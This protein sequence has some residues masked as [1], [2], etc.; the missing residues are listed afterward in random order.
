MYDLKTY[1][2]VF[3]LKDLHFLPWEWSLPFFSCADT[4]AKL[5][6]RQKSRGCHRNWLEFICTGN[7]LKHLEL[8]V[9]CENLT[10]FSSLKLWNYEIWICVCQAY[11]KSLVPLQTLPFLF[12]L[13]SSRLLNV[14][15]MLI[16]C[17]YFSLIS[18][19]DVFSSALV[20]QAVD[21][22]KS[23]QLH[24]VATSFFILLW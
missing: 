22:W 24:F 20:K 10:N 1:W 13:D 11:G 16:K 9:C 5:E 2:V 8:S 3:L 7:F 6:Q 12:N 17:L 15:F 19:N 4:P 23:C 14:C 18:V 21:P